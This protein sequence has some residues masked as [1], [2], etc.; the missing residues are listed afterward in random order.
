MGVQLP[1]A[2]LAKGRAREGWPLAHLGT[3]GEEGNESRRAQT[4]A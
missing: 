3:F 4:P 1:C 2:F